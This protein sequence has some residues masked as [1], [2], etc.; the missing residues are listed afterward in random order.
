M[1]QLKFS[2]ADVFILI[3]AMLLGVVCF[4]GINFYTLGNKPLSLSWAIGIA[5]TLGGTAF[6]ATVWKR[7]SCNFKTY[8]VLEVLFLILF[9]LSMG[10]V[11]YK[12][13]PH[14][15]VVSGQRTEIQSKLTASIT[16]AENMFT[17]YERYAENRKELYRD[18]LRGVAAAQNINPSEYVAYGFER[19]GVSN[20]R[21]I[22]NKM[23]VLH[24]NLFPTNHEEMKQ[25]ASNWLTDASHTLNNWWAWN[26]EIVDVV[27]KV[28]KNSQDWLE[29]GVVVNKTDTL[30]S[31]IKLSTIRGIGEQA[32]DFAFNLSF[33]DVKKYFTTLGS[34]TLLSTGLAALIYL[35]ML[36]SYLISK[37]ST[38]TTVG[39]TKDK[40]DFDIDF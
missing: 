3:G 1:N 20:D 10:I 32:E 11:S 31:L 17:E 35:L 40:G 5:G 36:L 33:D 28:E 13:F 38:K 7:T 23:F 6:L 22:E 19:N 12:I 8:F 29:K 30:K 26:F 16:Q 4:L 24:A 39:T 9:T 37:R 18:K 14:Y 25:I 15:F 2:K 21:Q 27:N 34:P